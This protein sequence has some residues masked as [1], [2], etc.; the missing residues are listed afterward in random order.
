MPKYKARIWDGNI[1]LYSELRKTLY[2]GLYSYLIEFAKKRDYLISNINEIEEQKVDLLPVLHKYTQEL[3]IHARNQ[4]ISLHDH[5]LDA[6]NHALT[7]KRCVIESPTASGKSAII[8]CISRYLMDKGKKCL[9]VVPNTALVEQFYSDFEDY[10]SAIDWNVANHCQ[11]IYSGFPKIVD[12]GTVF[13]TWQSIYKLPAQ[14]F[15]QFDCIVGDEAHTFTGQSL[16]SIMEKMTQVEYRI[17][18]TGS[19][20]DSNVHSL[21]LEGLFGAIRKIIST[22]ELQDSGKLSKIEIKALILQYS[23]EDKKLMK[24]KEY[25][26][27]LDFIIGY[28]K[29]NK[30]ITNLALKCTGNSL[31]LFQMVE[32]HGKILHKM[33]HDKANGSR[34]VYFI[35]GSTPT[36]ERERIRHAVADETNAIIVA[37]YGVYQQGVNIPSIENIIFASPSKSKIRNL[38]SIG[39]GLRL[40]SGKTCCNLY[41][42]TDNLQWKSSKNHTLKHGAER[43]KLYT[44]EKFPVKIIEVKI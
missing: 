26:E 23:D 14:W 36:E 38:Q 41:D 10:S 20:S 30:F 7:H 21:V 17:G 12:S 42:I 24:G 28:S 18:T 27:E 39:R 6:V 25:S 43:Y 5:Q 34:N 35:Y 22:K 29:R 44:E 1:R 2:I 31:I 33:I 8:Y 32:K 11:K 40:S 9:V 19:L 13:S 4:S 37:S 16:T 15:N 3:N